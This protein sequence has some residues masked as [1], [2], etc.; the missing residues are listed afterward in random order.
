MDEGKEICLACG[1][2]LEKHSSFWDGAV[3]YFCTQRYKDG[4]YCGCENFV[5]PGA[6]DG[7]QALDGR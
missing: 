7:K 1:H 2:E 6:Q 5:N 3:P 4:N